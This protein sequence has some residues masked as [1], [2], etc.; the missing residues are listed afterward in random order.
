MTR[1][2]AVDALRLEFSGGKRNAHSDKWN[3]GALVWL[4]ILHAVTRR[5]RSR[6]ELKQQQEFVELEEEERIC[7]SI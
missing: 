2:A 3:M 6:E 1:K 4:C 7:L 5:T